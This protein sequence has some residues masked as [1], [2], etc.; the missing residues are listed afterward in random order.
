MPSRSSKDTTNLSL[1]FCTSATWHLTQPRRK[2]PCRHQWRMFASLT[3]LGTTTGT[4]FAAM[5]DNLDESI[6]R[7]TEALQSAGM[8][9]NSIIVFSSDNGALPYGTHSNSGF[10]WPLRGT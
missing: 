2:S 6:G 3:T 5:V 7:L 8:L 9:E 1:C 4:M 10:N